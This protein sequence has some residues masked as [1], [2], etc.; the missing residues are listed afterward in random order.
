[1]YT[2]IPNY[3]S[4][5]NNLSD[6]KIDKGGQ[7]QSLHKFAYSLYFLQIFPKNGSPDHCCSETIRLKHNK[8][9]F[10]VKKEKLSS[11]TGICWGKKLHGGNSPHSRAYRSLEALRGR[12]NVMMK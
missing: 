7:V 6:L 3:E 2:D 10:V 11:L 8:I 9:I 5:M 12:K 4:E 1:M